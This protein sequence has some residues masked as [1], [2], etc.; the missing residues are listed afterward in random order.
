[1]RQS[2]AKAVSASVA[3]SLDEERINDQCVVGNDRVPGIVI[4][5]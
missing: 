2:S 3:A 5:C 4:V 1:M